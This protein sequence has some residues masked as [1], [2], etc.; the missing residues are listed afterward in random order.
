MIALPLIQGAA[1]LLCDTSAPF[2]QLH[3]SACAWTLALD[4]TLS[5]PDDA[6]G[7]L[8]ELLT[9]LF[10][11]GD[12]GRT[13]AALE[14]LAAS[15]TTLQRRSALIKAKAGLTSLAEINRVSKD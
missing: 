13:A 10:S 15:V 8:L 3:A 4:L 12:D 11:G 1:R 6:G 2:L 5:H 9:S 7:A 14:G